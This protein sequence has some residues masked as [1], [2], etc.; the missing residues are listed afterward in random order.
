[1]ID[2]TKYA[3]SVAPATSPFGGFGARCLEIPDV[4]CLGATPAVALEACIELARKTVETMNAPP[5]PLSTRT[6]SGHITVRVPPSLHRALVLE[7]RRQS[8]VL[9]TYVSLNTLI[10]LKLE[11]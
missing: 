9:N 3:Y 1:M 7:A 6:F 8:E 11:G 10:N 2:V 5:E 4:S